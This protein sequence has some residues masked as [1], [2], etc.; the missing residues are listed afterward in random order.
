LDE[1]LES[2]EPETG[3]MFLGKTEDGEKFTFRVGQTDAILDGALMYR[4]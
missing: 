3:D 1:F 2:Y 4:D